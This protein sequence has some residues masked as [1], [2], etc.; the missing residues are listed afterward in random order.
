M[1]DILEYRCKFQTHFMFFFFLRLQQN[2]HYM[3][4]H[5]I[6]LPLLRT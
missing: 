1:E 5:L 3:Y 4:F 6:F 2:M